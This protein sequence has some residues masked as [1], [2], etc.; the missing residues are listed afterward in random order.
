MC[1]GT[2]VCS[3]CLTVLYIRDSCIVE[4]LSKVC[5]FNWSRLLKHLVS[6]TPLKV[7]LG[8]VPAL[9]QCRQEEGQQI[10][11]GSML[12]HPQCNQSPCQ[13]GSYSGQDG[14]LSWHHLQHRGLGAG[15]RTVKQDAET[16]SVLNSGL[17]KSENGGLLMPT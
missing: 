11:S 2:C 10:E 12:L 13:E 14:G 15:V 3:S 1:S 7:G 4:R 17:C 9:S 5:L 6:V 8:S 16:T